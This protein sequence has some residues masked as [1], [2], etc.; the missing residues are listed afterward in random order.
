MFN[1]L[2]VLG[3]VLE[4][5]TALCLLEDTDLVD[6]RGLGMAAASHLPPFPAGL[7][8]KQ[9]VDEPRTFLALVQG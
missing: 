4:I 2:G 5:L 7:H 1:N 3:A 9:H 8:R 6:R